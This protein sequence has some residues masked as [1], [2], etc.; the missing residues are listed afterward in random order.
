M[1]DKPERSKGIDAPRC[2][3]CGKRH[4]G[5]CLNQGG[6]GYL[7]RQQQEARPVAPAA[8]AKALK[9]AVAKAAAVKPKAKK[10]RR[11]MSTGGK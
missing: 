11:A 4:W 8:K 9:A 6:G 7:Y 5:T 2:K 10:S 3:V 1:S